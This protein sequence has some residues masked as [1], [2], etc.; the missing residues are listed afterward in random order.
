LYSFGAINIPLEI[1]QFSKG[2]SVSNV[3]LYLNSTDGHYHLKGML[4]NTLPETRSGFESI[5]VN[6]DDKA[7]NSTVDS[8]S[9]SINVT[10]DPGTSV[11]F[12]IPTMYTVKQANQFQFMKATITP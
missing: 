10:I 11:P 8:E 4:K 7:T 1:N 6:F 5:L 9:G 2:W 3:M 12:D